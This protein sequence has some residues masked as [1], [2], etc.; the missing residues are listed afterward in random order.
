[1]EKKDNMSNKSSG[2]GAIKFDYFTEMDEI[3]SEDPDVQP[4]CTASSLR[5]IKYGHSSKT[6]VDEEDSSSEDNT[7]IKKKPKLKERSPLTKQLT[8][9]ERNCKKR[10]EKKEQR[11]KDLMQRQDAAL[12]I[13][14]SI[15]QSFIKPNDTNNS[16]RT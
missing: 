13:L 10:E 9:Y 15:A 12:T 6:S 5:G 4:V 2:A 8:V 3:F 14:K 16:S 7:P 1:M 11:H